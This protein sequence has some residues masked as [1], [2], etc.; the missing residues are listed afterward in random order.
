MK[1]T[2]TNTEI[3][4]IMKM[5]TDGLSTEE[6]SARVFITPDVIERVV[7]VRFPK[8]TRK[9]KSAIVEAAV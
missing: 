4:R 9:P 7:S 2:T 6:I 8:K 1:S 5:H 3:R